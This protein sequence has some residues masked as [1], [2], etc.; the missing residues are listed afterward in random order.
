MNFL[1]KRIVVFGAGKASK[2]VFKWFAYRNITPFVVVDNNPSLWGVCVCNVSISSPDILRD[3]DFD[4]IV[5]SSRKFYDE[6]VFD[7]SSKYAVPQ[8]KILKGVF[9]LAGYELIDF[10]ENNPDFVDSGEMELILEKIRREGELFSWNYPYGHPNV[11]ERISVEVHFDDTCSLFYAL[12]NGKRMYMSHNFTDAKRVRDYVA[13]LMIEQN[14]KSPHRYLDTDFTFDGGVVLDAG[15]AEGN[16]SLDVIDKASHIV[17]VETNKAWISALEHTFAP[18]KDKVSIVPKFLSD[19]DNETSITI[20]TLAQ[21]FNFDFIKMDIEGAEPLALKGGK[22][23][24]QTANSL[25]LAV[26]SYHNFDDERK[27][28]VILKDTGYYYTTTQGYMVFARDIWKP[29]RFV[30][31]IVRGEKRV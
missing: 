3:I 17:L 21:Q 28:K 22:K 12:Y 10:Y 8:D 30:R 23:T 25:K 5:V 24:L 9:A 13:S 27:I 7:L 19:V 2:I 26:C 15:A 16:F 11:F 14:I 20:D 4:Y 31:C 6:I 18:Y 1:G 29:Q